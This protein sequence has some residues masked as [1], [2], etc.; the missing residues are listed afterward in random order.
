MDFIFLALG[1]KPAPIFRDS[2][3]PTGPEGGL[4]VNNYLQ[5]SS[6]PDIF[7]GGDCIYFQDKPLDKVGVYAVRQNPVLLN[8]LMARLEGGGGAVALLT[9]WQ[10]YATAAA[11]V[12]SLFLLQNA[13]QAGMLVAVG[14]AQP[15]F[16]VERAKTR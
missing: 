10:L 4:L 12:G 14:V 8:N 5:S 2:G 16:L 11:G 6:Y 7:G 9:S 13:L 15:L 1:V 3:I